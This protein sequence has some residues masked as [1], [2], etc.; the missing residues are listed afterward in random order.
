MITHRDEKTYINQI[1]KENFSNNGDIHEHM[2]IQTGENKYK[3]SFC[4]KVFLYTS[5]LKIHMK[6]HKE[7][8]PCEN[9]TNV[10]HS[11]KKV[12]LASQCDKEI[13]SETNIFRIEINKFLVK[14]KLPFQCGRIVST[15][16]NCFYDSVLALLEDPKVSRG[17]NLRA[18]NITNYKDLRIALAE[19]METNETLHEIGTFQT[20]RNYTL[21]QKK[22]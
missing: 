11:T 10:I 21:K 16:G 2:I 7:N 18:K 14:L 9:Y 1:Y 20:Q 22:P 4:E 13:T 5:A 12:F 3:C 8:K 15:D 6:I 19:F 17:I